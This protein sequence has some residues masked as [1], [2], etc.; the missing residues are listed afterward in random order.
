MAYPTPGEASLIT[1]DFALGSTTPSTSFG[2]GYTLGY[3]FTDPGSGISVT[4]TA[5]GLTGNGLTTFQT[6]QVARTAYGL[7]S[8][9]TGDGTCTGNVQRVD[10]VG[11]LDFILFQF[12]APVDLKGIVIDP[13]GTSFDRDASYWVGN[14]ADNLRNILP[15]KGLLGL[16]GLGFGNQQ[17]VSNSAGSSALTLFLAGDSVTSLLFGTQ[18][19]LTTCSTGSSNNCDRFYIKSLI[20][21]AVQTPEPGTLF[22]LGSGLVG[23]AAFGRRLRKRG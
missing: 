20:D 2:S 11:Q 23:V 22:L 1:W 14:T 13:G 6:A 12:S 9:N 21:D 15:G 17:N 3:T 16:S 5:W 18:A 19:A 4:A 7:G 10:N 8:C